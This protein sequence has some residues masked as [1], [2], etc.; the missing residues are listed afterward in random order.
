MNLM[1]S[2][3][4][5]GKKNILQVSFVEASFLVFFYAVLMLE[6]GGGVYEGLVLGILFTGIYIVRLIHLLNRIDSRILKRLAAY[7]KCFPSKFRSYIY[8]HSSYYPLFDRK[9]RRGF[10][11]NIL[12]FL[13]EVNIKYKRGN[14]EKVPPLELRLLIA[15]GF[16]T[17]LVGRPDWELPLPGKI[18]VFSKDR[19]VKDIKNGKAEYAALATTETLFLTEKNLVHS[20]YCYSDGYNN[21]FHEIAHY[22]D[23]EDYDLDGTPSSERFIK[24]FVQKPR[25][26]IRLWREI[27]ETEFEK[28]ANG[29]LPIRSYATK[30]LGEF[31]ACATELFFENPGELNDSSKDLYFLLKA[32][33]NFDPLELLH[34]S[35]G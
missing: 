29:E 16:A 3:S 5:K 13:S 28:A 14:E 30:N 26:C 20:F 22:F 27:L 23:I 19:I 11:R 7:I 31:L 6:L 21:I 32:F 24:G 1:S 2:V 8:D 17:L 35:T 25:E 18:I 10:E 4:K 33:Y 9:T 15:M 12:I 34:G